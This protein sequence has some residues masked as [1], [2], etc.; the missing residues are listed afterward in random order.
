MN[1]KIGDKVILNNNDVKKYESP[2]NG[3]FVVIQCWDN[4]TV[5]LQYGTMKISH[6]IRRIKPYTSEKNVE[7]ITPENMC[8]DV[9]ILS[10]VI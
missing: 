5:T 2:Y 6:N 8:D 10:L 7:D 9:N 3:P 4:S 1:S